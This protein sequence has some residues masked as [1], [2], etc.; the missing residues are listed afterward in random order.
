MSKYLV[1]G[2][3]STHFEYNEEDSTVHC[4]HGG[5]SGTIKFNEDGSCDVDVGFMVIPYGSYDFTD[6]GGINEYL[7]NRNE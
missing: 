6:I 4:T 5:W 1:A 7:R 3:G 2:N